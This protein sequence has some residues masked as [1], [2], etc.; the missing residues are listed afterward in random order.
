MKIDS[1]YLFKNKDKF[2]RV[3]QQ[4][5]IDLSKTYVYGFAI[6]QDIANA[7][8]SLIVKFEFDA[9]LAVVLP[10]IEKLQ[11]AIEALLPDEK[12]VEICTEKILRYSQHSFSD[13]VLRERKGWDCVI[14]E[15]KQ[16]EKSGESLEKSSID[17]ELIK[18]IP[19]ASGIVIEQAIIH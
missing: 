15:G 18:H 16:Q 4:H 19:L 14:R 1:S 6:G 8:L 10:R 12:S 7:D 13:K 3:F 2:K 9:E 5:E 17:P 11:A